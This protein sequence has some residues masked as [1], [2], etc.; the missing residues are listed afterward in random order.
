MNV[1][2]ASWTDATGNP[3]IAGTLVV[4]F[5]SCQ[6][7]NNFKS[8]KEGRPV[9]DEK[10]FITKLIPGDSTFNVDREMRE[11]DKEDYPLQWARWKEKQENIIPGTPV[12]FWPGITQNQIAVMK[13]LNISTIEQF[14]NLPDSNSTKIMGFNDLRNQALRLSAVAKGELFIEKINAET[15]AKLLMQEAEIERLRVQI[16]ELGEPKKRGRPKKEV[17]VAVPTEEIAT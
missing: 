1:E 5:R 6:K 15:D 11:Q 4:F 2:N 17:A 13:A 9:F 10:I 8:N 16:M 7:K 12:E 3:V 14:A